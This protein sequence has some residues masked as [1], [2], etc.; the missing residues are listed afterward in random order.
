MNPTNKRVLVGHY[1]GFDIYKDRFGFVIQLDKKNKWRAECRVDNP[2]WANALKLEI[3][4]WYGN[5]NNY[6]FKR[7]IYR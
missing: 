3:A 5:H 1:R 6:Q 4:F 2:Y 7:R